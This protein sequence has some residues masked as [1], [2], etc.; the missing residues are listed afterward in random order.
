[1]ANVL[2]AML[3]RYTDTRWWRTTDAACPW[4]GYDGRVVRRTVVWPLA[5][6]GLGLVNA[7]AY[8]RRGPNA[9][10]SD[11]SLFAGETPAFDVPEETD[12]PSWGPVIELA[13]AEQ[14]VPFDKLGVVR[15]VNVNTR[16]ACVLRLYDASGRIDEEAAHQLDELAADARDPDGIRTKVIDRRVL[17]L[18]F[19]AAYHFGAKRIEIVSGYR[20]PGQRS[21]GRH[22]AGRAIDFRIG[23]VSAPLLASYLRKSP[24]VGVGVYTNPWTQFVH[25]DDRDRSYHWIDASPPGRRWRGRAIGDAGMA[26]RDESYSPAADWPEGTM[27]SPLAIAERQRP[28]DE[29]PDQA[30]SP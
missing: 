6:L 17:Q 16:R 18:L 13:T 29:D 28:I 7:A 23:G 1:M 3:L 8:A 11:P 5:I 15:L 30:S 27:P 10:R 20:E 25:L 2:P 19:R 4:I 26:K 24:R 12:V 14:G 21:E 22:G 9:A